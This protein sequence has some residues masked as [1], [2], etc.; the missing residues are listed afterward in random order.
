MA[1]E[2]NDHLQRGRS[3]RRNVI[4]TFNVNP[5]G[6]DIHDVYQTHQTCFFWRIQMPVRFQT[7]FETKLKKLLL[8]DGI[9]GSR[10]NR[11]FP[12]TK[13]RR[14]REINFFQAGI[15]GYRTN[16]FER[17]RLG[18]F[19]LAGVYLAWFNLL[20]YE[21]IDFI[22]NYEFYPVCTLNQRNKFVLFLVYTPI[23]HCPFVTFDA[24]R[25]K[26]IK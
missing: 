4:F 14:N 17:N 7:C 12:S 21:Q 25:A 8:C 3:V 20:D 6:M 11:V 9:Y 22:R 24:M 5:E 16:Y 26:I 18:N 23:F 10:K 13:T 15:N 19:I 2:I 1:S